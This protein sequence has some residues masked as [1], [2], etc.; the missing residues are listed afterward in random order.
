MSVQIEM[1][2]LR[3]SIFREL[4]LEYKLRL[5]VFFLDFRGGIPLDLS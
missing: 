3:I 5:L 2:K 1:F 4:I